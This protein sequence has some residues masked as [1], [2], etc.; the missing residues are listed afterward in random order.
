[1]SGEILLAACWKSRISPALT[2]QQQQ[3]GVSEAGQLLEDRG[4]DL[5]RGNDGTLRRT[6]ARTAAV[7]AA[8]TNFSWNY[9]SKL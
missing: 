6:G 4:R 2:K 9:F 3:H 8:A 7:R 1:M 5:P